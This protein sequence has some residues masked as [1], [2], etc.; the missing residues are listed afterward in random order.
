MRPVLGVLLA[1]SLAI[2]VYFWRQLDTANANASSSALTSTPVPASAATVSPAFAEQPAPPTSR[3]F[4]KWLE[5]GNYDQLEQALTDALKASPLEPELLLIEAELMVHTA[6]LSEAILHYYSLLDL[7]LSARHYHDIE[8][9]IETLV[10]NAATQLKQS[11][12][13][14]ILAQFMEPLFQ[15][16]PLEEKYAR[17]L[18][19]AY[20]QQQKPTL[21]EDVLAALPPDDA[22]IRRIRSLL[23][24]Q[25][26]D[27]RE[28]ATIDTPQSQSDAITIALERGRDKY[29]AYVS[30]GN[31]PARLLFD[32]GASTTAITQSLYDTL[33]RREAL[34]FIGNFTVNTAAGPIRASMFEAPIMTIGPLRFEQTP[35]L[36]LPSSALPDADGLLGMNVLRAYHFGIDQQHATLTLSPH[37][38]QTN[39]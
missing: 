24:T 39:R 12:S 13:W 10:N 23:D 7:P 8:R 2:N 33:K 28:E 9:R 22:N 14:S 38:R 31:Q 29:F 3:D 26:S 4:R 19:E 27:A 34:P 37:Q 16:M 5:L 18:A 35:V 1:L 21:T 25:A 20:A 15:R 32:T 17:W 6:P 36:V 30:F 11:G